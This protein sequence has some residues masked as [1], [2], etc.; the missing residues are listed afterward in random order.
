MAM[1]KRILLFVLTAM[2]CA[3]AAA[4]EKRPNVIM[5]MAD[6]MGYETVAANGCDDYKT[7]NIDAM[8]KSGM[9]F[10]NAFAN[11]ICTPSRVRLMTGKH[12]VRNYT[13]FGVLDLDQKTF[14]HYFRDAGYKTCISGKWQLGDAVDDPPG[15]FG[16]DESCLWQLASGNSHVI[17]GQRYDS[18]HTSPDLTINGEFMEFRNGEFGPDVCVEFIE[19]FLE[20]NSDSPF[21]VYYPMILPHCPFVPTPGTPDYDPASPGSPSYKG[22]PMYFTNMVEHVDRIV[23][24]IVKKVD[25][26]GLSDDTLIVFTGDNGTDS[27]IVTSLNGEPVA[28]GKG[29]AH[30]DSGVRTPFFVTMPGTVQAGEVRHD[31]VDFS[32]LLP[33]FCELAGIKTSDPQLD[34]VSLMP[35]LTGR[36]ERNKP[37]SY[38]FYSRGHGTE[39]ASSVVVRT[40]THMAFRTGGPAQPVEF[41]NCSKPYARELHE[42][43]SHSD[44][45]KKIYGE[46]V[47]VIA[48]YDSQF[49][50]DL[51]EVAKLKWEDSLRKQ[52][53]KRRKGKTPEELPNFIVI[54]TDDQGYQDL[55]CFG[56]PNIKTPHIDRM[57]QEGMRFTDFYSAASVCTPSRAALLT[58]CYPQRVGNLGVLFPKHKKGLNPSETT[59]AKMLK[60][61]GYATACIGKWHLGHM[62]AFLPT[63]HGFD[64]YFGIPYSNDM[65][66]DKDM[67]LAD[68]MVWRNGIDEVTFRKGKGGGP[69][70]M[71]GKEVIE[72][73]ADQS[74][75]TKRYT[76]EAV[77]FIEANKDEPFFLYLPHTMPHIPLYVTP[78]FEG[79]SG[80]GL[81]GDCIEEIDWSVG[82]ILTALK[83]HGIDKKTCIVYTA[84]NGPWNLKGNATDKVKGNMNRK[85]GGSALPL[86]GYKFSY[87]EGGVRV[88]TVMWW[89]GHIPAGKECQEVAGTI[90]LLPTFA[91]L[92]GAKLPKKKIDGKSI[93]PLLEGKDGAMSPHGAWIYKNNGIRCG[94]WKYLSGKLYDLSADISES[95]DLSGQHPELVEYLKEKLEAHRDE[96]KSNSRLAGTLGDT[97]GPA[98]A[99]SAKFDGSKVKLGDVFTS[100]QVPGLVNKRIKISGKLETSSVADEVVLA[101][102]GNKVGY[103]LYLQKGDLVFA[104][105]N[106]K[107]HLERARVPIRVGKTTFTA[108]LDEKG[109]LMLQVGDAAPVYSSEGKHWITRVPIGNLSIGFDEANPVD[110]SAPKT[111]FSGK[112]SGL[113][114]E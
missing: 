27:P 26:L 64:S 79:K 97:S 50:S 78:E 106:G 11:P 61:H 38:C 37:W 25:E 29:K 76:E 109:R 18:R 57:A 46:L 33:T 105:S 3:A 99:V 93:V 35:V 49:Q 43:A 96:I 85:T 54:F 58:G 110:P 113:N 59:I 45:D 39:S 56:S 14:G 98:Q 81:Y 89:P 15:H 70:L 6:D 69:P 82:Q 68:N 95:T 107:G 36:G 102:G 52:L 21:F 83:K 67:V 86:K 17:D 63:S 62:D 12:N 32:D 23:G 104:V 94:K 8:A 75:L 40:A 60:G 100:S 13:R 2:Y 84:D 16:F 77:R 19:K 4:K 5:I 51:D 53:G 24:R 73:P 10:T 22:D 28:G 80:A 91:M 72:C 31:L 30:H 47:E 88:P 41:Y 48:R 20:A 111:K 42:E 103:S 7:P 1:L 101:H 90:D 65:G 114:I 87:N 71:R 55:G 9:R 108:G 74:T 66:I 92:S 44:E 34:G 112:L